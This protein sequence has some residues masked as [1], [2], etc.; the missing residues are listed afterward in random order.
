MSAEP[1]VKKAKIIP[2]SVVKIG[3]RQNASDGSK[4]YLVSVGTEG[5]PGLLWCA[6]SDLP[7]KMKAS[8]SPDLAEM[9]MVCEATGGGEISFDWLTNSYI[10]KLSYLFVIV[11]HT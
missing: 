11:L 6:D 3:K 4:Q 5:A 8:K 7:E 1:P 9:N 10:G 2:D